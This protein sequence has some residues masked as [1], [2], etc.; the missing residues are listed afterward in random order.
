MTHTSDVFLGEIQWVA[1]PFAPQGWALCNGQVLLI[2]Q[3]PALFS[4]LG[5]TYGGDGRATYALPDLRG[6]TPIGVSQNDPLGMTRGQETEYLLAAQTPSH[7]HTIGVSDRRAASNDPNATNQVFA[8]GTRAYAPRAA[9]NATMS[10]SAVASAGSEAHPNMQPYTVL[11]AII[12]TDGI[13]P[14]RSW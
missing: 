3:N 7:S 14:S 13:F 2:S 4:L 10:S 6:R 8:G 1:F 5:T 12:A 9:A 11:N